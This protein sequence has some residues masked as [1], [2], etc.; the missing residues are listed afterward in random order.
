MNKVTKINNPEG[1][2][3]YLITW[4][5][6]NASLKESMHPVLEGRCTENMKVLLSMEIPMQR[7]LANCLS[8]CTLHRFLRQRIVNKV[9]PFSGI[10]QSWDFKLGVHVWGICTDLLWYLPN[11]V[12]LDDKQKL[13]K[14]FRNRAPYLNSECEK[15]GLGWNVI[16]LFVA[17]WRGVA[18]TNRRALT[19]SGS[20]LCYCPGLAA[21]CQA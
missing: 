16:S 20:W 8:F 15:Y 13:K 6:S 7:W 14:L 21:V 2:N 17:A 18:C 11:D 10:L 1:F 12:P 9:T 4:R 19:T 5:V 3:F